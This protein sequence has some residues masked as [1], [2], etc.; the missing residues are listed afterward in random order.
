MKSNKRPA[1]DSPATAVPS[2]ERRRLL[3]VGLKAAP[4]VFTIASKPVLGS[5]MCT[6]MSA[7]GSASSATARA[8]QVCS[9]LTPE[10]WKMYAA[11]WPVPYCAIATPY[12]QEPTAYHCPT[13]GFAG[14]IFGDRTMLEVIDIGEAGTGLTS[15]GRWMVAALLNAGCGRTPVL[16]EAEVR[17]IWNSMINTGYYE[18]TAGVQWGPADV[19]A[20]LQTT[21]G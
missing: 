7:A 6:T 4:V 16:D 14:R 18:P 20:Y 19:I 11:E 21:M 17:N 13:T 8:V 9:G 2:D 10:Q 15:L 5:T 12:S 1:T 3:Q